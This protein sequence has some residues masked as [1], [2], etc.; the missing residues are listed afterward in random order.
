MNRRLVAV[1]PAL[2]VAALAVSGCRGTPPAP[3]AP[4]PAPVP[5]SG[6]QIDEGGYTM[7][8]IDATGSKRVL[9]AMWAAPPG[10]AHTTDAGGPAEYWVDFNHLMKTIGP[11]WTITRTGDTSC[12]AWLSNTACQPT[13]SRT[14]YVASSTEDQGLDCGTSIPAETDASSSFLLPGS[15][16]ILVDAG[17]DAGLDAWLYVDSNMEYWAMS[18]L[19]G[20][21]GAQI[22]ADSANYRT[23]T[24]LVS[25][26][27]LNPQMTHWYTPSYQVLSPDP[28]T[29]PPTPPPNCGD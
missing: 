20:D 8:G 9:A 27:C 17:A 16:E 23:A 13:T 4:P 28:C 21:A 6:Y 25:Y 1:L 2:V 22:K 5:H 11:P 12:Q 18:H 7:T 10:T 3:P 15:Y 24:G 19:I 29:T 14:W 26:A